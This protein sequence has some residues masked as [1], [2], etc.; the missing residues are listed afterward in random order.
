MASSGEPHWSD[1]PDDDAAEDGRRGEAFFW[2]FAVVALIVGIGA[3]VT[4]DND[5][6]DATFAVGADELVDDGAVTPVP[7][8]TVEPTPTPTE[9]AALVQVRYAVDAITLEGVVPAQPVVDALVTAAAE[10]VGAEAV[11]NELGID[12]ASSLAGGAVVITGEIDD[13]A[14]RAAVVGAFGDIGLVIDDR[15]VIAGSNRSIEE[16]LSEDPT[17]AQFTDFLVASGVMAD[18][19][20]DTEDG[21]T[22][23]VPTDEAVIELVDIAADELGDADQLREVLQYHVVGGS[24]TAR[25]L[26][27]VT[28]LTSLQGESIPVEVTGDGALLIGGAAVL[29]AD[30]DATNGVVHVI[31]TMLLQ[32]TLRTEVELNNLVTLDPILFG[33]GSAEIVDES[34]P[35]LDQ[36]AQILL[37]N[38]LG[39]VEIQGH[40]DSDGDAQINLDLSQLRADAV[41]DYLVDQG[42]DPNRLNATGYGETALKIDPEES[43]EDKAANRRIEFRVD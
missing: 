6:T 38:P 40:T 31:D 14:N 29:S 26:Q 24:L 12:A 35:I 37:A 41:A 4:F 43:D 3:V 19:G 27:Q 42:V 9:V 11:T 30:I 13:E 36:A 10:L 5:S 33:Q 2:I 17:V 34:F 7:L 22:V 8:P 23:F 1:A 39:R 15:M 25:D 21:F 16:V 28:A 18:L 20:V 32:G